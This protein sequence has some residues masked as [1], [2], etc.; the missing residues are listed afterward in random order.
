MA[1]KTDLTEMQ[2]IFCAEFIKTGNAYQ[3]ALTAGYSESFART[4]AGQM[5]NKPKIKAYINSLKEERT[6]ALQDAIAGVDE[7]LV[8]LSDTMRGKTGAK[9][10]ERLKSAE[11]LG[12]TYAMFTDKVLQNEVKQVVFTDGGLLPEDEDDIE[13]LTMEETEFLEEPKEDEDGSEE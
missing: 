6:E 3:S 4:K 10:S 13:L 2:K 9:P 5:V 12:K 8:F 11:L 1:S 7:I